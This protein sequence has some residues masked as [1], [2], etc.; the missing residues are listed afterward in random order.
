[1]NHDKDQIFNHDR[2]THPKA[3]F[4]VFEQMWDIVVFEQQACKKKTFRMFEL[5][6]I[7]HHKPQSPPRKRTPA[8]PQGLVSFLAFGQY[9]KSLDCP[10][11]QWQGCQGFTKDFTSHIFSF[12]GQ[13]LLSSRSCSSSKHHRLTHKEWH[14]R[15][16][17]SKL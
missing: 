4:L 16:K 5:Q 6:G 9:W 8:K 12:H 7:C 2:Q 13:Q 17:L 10:G 15:I 1:M 14:K 11:G 3:C